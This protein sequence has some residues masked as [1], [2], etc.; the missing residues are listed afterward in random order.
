M[1]ILALEHEKETAHAADFA[2]HLK[3][4]AAH[5]WRLQQS[6][7]VREV[8]FNAKQHTAVLILE[9]VSLEEAREALD[10]LPLVKAGLIDFE[11]IELAPYDGFAR[12]FAESDLLS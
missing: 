4:E 6:D 10:Q 1:K 11:L 7:L 3:D 12:L 8:Y 5:V 9:C 2:P